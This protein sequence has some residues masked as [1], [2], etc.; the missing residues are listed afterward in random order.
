[1]MLFRLF[2]I[3]SLCEATGSPALSISDFVF[4]LIGILFL[5]LDDRM[6]SHRIEKNK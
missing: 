2:A 1:M 5:W 4:T 3:L 6:I